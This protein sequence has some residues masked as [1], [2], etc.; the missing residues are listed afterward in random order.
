MDFV[1]TSLF[2]LFLGGSFLS[3][4]Y[5]SFRLAPFVFVPSFLPLSSFFLLLFPFQVPL[6]NRPHLPIC[7]P[8]R[9]FPGVA[10]SPPKNSQCRACVPAAATQNRARSLAGQKGG[11]L[12][13]Q[14]R[15]TRGAMDSMDAMRHH[16]HLPMQSGWASGCLVAL[17]LCALSRALDYPIATVVLRWFMRYRVQRACLWTTSPYAQ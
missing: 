12:G 16:A 2:H 9:I 7:T 10:L 13:V 3:L 11:Q 4:S 5:L 6:A 1:F 17:I 15:H 8:A 14:A